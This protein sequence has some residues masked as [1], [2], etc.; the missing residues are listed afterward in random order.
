MKST[1]LLAGALL[2][3]G[4]FCATSSNA[5]TAVYSSSVAFNA[6]VTDV[7]IDDY[8]NPGYLFS[9]SDADM[10]AVVG[11]TSYT[12]TGFNNL[13][14]VFGI[15]DGQHSYCAGCNGSFRLGFLSTSI[16]NANGVGGVGADY[17]A[18]DLPP[19]FTA[20]VTFGDGSTSDYALNASGTG[21]YFGI[22]S[23]LG[24]KSID[25]GPSGGTTIGGRFAIDN[26]AIGRVGV[27]PEPATW[28]MMIIGFG[29]T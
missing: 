20:F 12:S 19:S 10:T 22:T 3:F 6:A 29:A 15:G 23:D 11:Q 5:A 7:I 4:A 9:Q 13:N 14:I 2:I 1:S 24:I 21:G 16:S 25:F 27:V 17:F 8:E 26:L 28:A 18:N